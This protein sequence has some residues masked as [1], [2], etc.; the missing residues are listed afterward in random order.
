MKTL[1]VLKIIQTGEKYNLLSTSDNTYLT[2]KNDGDIN[3]IINGKFSLGIN[4]SIESMLFHIERDLI[5]Y[6]TLKWGKEIS[7]LETYVATSISV[8]NRTNRMSKLLR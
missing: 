1:N 7:Q 8:K 3:L 6:T 5:D 4:S 2:K